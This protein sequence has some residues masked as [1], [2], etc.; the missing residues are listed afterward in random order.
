MQTFPLNPALYDLKKMTVPEDD[1]TPFEFFQKYKYG[2]I[3]KAQVTG[4]GRPLT[5][6]EEFSNWTEGGGETIE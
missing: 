1:L 6:A 4:I 2:N 5:E 3:L